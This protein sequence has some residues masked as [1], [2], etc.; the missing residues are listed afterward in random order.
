VIGSGTAPLVAL[1][2]DLV[3]SIP[4]APAP[5]CTEATASAAVTH[6]RKTWH[7][8]HMV[9]SAAVIVGFSLIHG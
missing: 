5:D 4:R 2:V 3:E 8:G 9:V 7:P 6:P 1:L